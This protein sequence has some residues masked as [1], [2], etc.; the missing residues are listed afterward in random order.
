[1]TFIPHLEYPYAVHIDEWRQIAHANTLLNAATVTN[2][3]PF[4][5]QPSSDEVISLELGYHLLLAV[6]QRVTGI[7]WID[8][9]R[10]LPSIIFVFTV[11]SVYIFAKRMGFGWEAAFFTSLI[12][13]TVGILGPAFLVPVA[14]GLTFVCL[15]LFMAFNFRSFWSYLVIC[16][17]VSYLAILHPQSA[18]LITMILV[19]LILLG[20][21]G[22]IKHS[23]ATMLAI[24]LPFIVTLPKTSGLILYEASSLFTKKPLPIYHDFLTIITGYGYL[25]TIFCLLGTFVL[26]ARGG[27]KNYS[28]VLGLLILLAMLV[29]F[30]ALHY[31]VG[32]LYLRGLLFAMLM[33]SIVAGAGLSALR[34]LE[35]P[36]AAAT[37]IN[38]SPV[39]KTARFLLCLI[40]IGATL[41][42]AIPD[43]LDEGYYHMIDETDYNAFVWIRNNVD[44]SFQKAILDP[45]KATAFTAITG[46][47]VY[48]R[49]HMAPGPID[50]AAYDFLKSGSTNTTFLRENGITIIYTRV[51]DGNRQVEYSPRNPDLIEVT[52]NVYLL[53]QSGDK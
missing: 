33:M 23:V 1:M 48:T 53:R 16:I 7:S 45:W 18:I 15:V 27:R 29:V 40:V 21:I 52:G 50:N 10:Y 49:I 44:A 41:A 25:P 47:Y 51:D 42:I 38:K 20:L 36:W 34:T 9:A 31:G 14:L 39:M 35:L 22:D 11:L 6:F 12:P 4:S 46:K 28:L 32:T 2:L 26:T 5:G 37:R 13:T 3:D 17:S 43:R 30:Y 8:I 19:P 24:T